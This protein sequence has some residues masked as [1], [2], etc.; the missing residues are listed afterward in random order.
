M[1]K[2]K[3]ISVTQAAE[4]LNV[5]PHY[6]RKLIREGKI[7]ATQNPRNNV[8]Q[9]DLDSFETYKGDS[10]NQQ[11]LNQLIKGI[12][13]SNK[14][15]VEQLEDYFGDV[16]TYFSNAGY[17]ASIID[18]NDCSM[19]DDVLFNMIPRKKGKNKKFKKLTL[20]LQSPGGIL[21]AAV[22]FSTIIRHY[23]ESYEVIVP[24]V[25]KS[26]ATLLALSSDK[27]YFT[28]ISELGPVDPIIQSPTNPSLRVPATAIEDFFQYYGELAGDTD[29]NSLLNDSIKKKIEENLDPYLL[30]SFKGA[31]LYSKDQV[32]A[33]LTD[34]IMKGESQEL[35]NEATEVFT[36]K[37]RS[38]SHP[39]IPDQLIK[40]HIGETITNNT[41]LKVIKM[42]QNFY[43]QFMG[44]NNI[45]KLLGNRDENK[46][47]QQPIRN[48]TNI[49]HSKQ[50]AAVTSLK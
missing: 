41:Q 38:H 16:I 44:M 19:L 7:N 3:F 11:E 8:Y 20:F 10:S 6:I 33:A 40:Y 32:K 22:K 12:T 42:L 34:H 45:I 17:P 4:R 36:T 48:V 35:I 2:N 37:Y 9:I 47:L 31:L 46:I 28:T 24:M 30:G 23:A 25:A 39:I 43:Q 29:S 15:A 26:A 18:Q 5:T 49:P 13:I 14:E 21:E 27:I 1:E 50:I